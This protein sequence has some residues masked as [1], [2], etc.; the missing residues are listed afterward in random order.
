MR[1]LMPHRRTEREKPI[2]MDSMLRRSA[3]DSS[4]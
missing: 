3:D 1:K 4:R 2:K